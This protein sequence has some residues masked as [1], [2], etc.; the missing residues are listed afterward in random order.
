MTMFG[1]MLRVVA[2]LAALGVVASAQDIAPASN[3]TVA[4]DNSVLLDPFTFE[5]PETAGHH[6]GG[7]WHDGSGGYFGDGYGGYDGEHDHVWGHDVA[8]VDCSGHRGFPSISEAVA[9]VA[10]FGE[11]RVLSGF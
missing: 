6:H 3:D 2:L 8:I 5:T 7:H 10:P 9:H 4:V 1:G 11:V